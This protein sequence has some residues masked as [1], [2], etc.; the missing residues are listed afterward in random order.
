MNLLHGISILISWVTTTL[1]F[2]N[3]HKPHPP[4]CFSTSF[5]FSGLVKGLTKFNSNLTNSK[6]ITP[7]S[8]SCRTI[9]CLKRICLFFPLNILLLTLA[10]ATWLSQHID[11]NRVGLVYKGISAKRFL[12]H[13]ASELAFS[14]VINSASIVDR[15]M[16]V[17][18]AD[19]QEIALPPRIKTFQ[20]VDFISFESKIQFA[21]LNPSRTLGSPLK[22]KP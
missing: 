21:S 9:L 11:T 15:V 16:Q 5:L 8:S 12:S 17:C 18:W 13:S 6:D 2:Y 10:I 3:R 19:F 20:L 1:D 4:R 22:H 14:K 7:V